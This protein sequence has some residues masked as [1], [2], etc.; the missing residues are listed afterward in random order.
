MSLNLPDWLTPTPHPILPTFTPEE[1]EEVIQRPGGAE[2]YADWFNKRETLIKLAEADPLRHGFE[3]EHTYPDGTVVKPW[4]DARKLLDEAEILGIF[5]GNRAAKSVFAAKSVC[6]AAMDFPGALIVCLSESEMTSIATQQKLIWLFL[7]KYIEPFNNKRDSTVKVNY[8]QAN[9]FSDK[10]LVFPNKSEMYFLTYNQDPGMFEGWEFGAQE[11]VLQR[12]GGQLRDAGKRVP[13]NVGAWADESLTLAWLQM[14]SRRLKFRKS[15]LIWA[16]TPVKGITPAIKEFVGSSAVTLKA[17]PSELLNKRKNFPELEPGTMP[18]IQRPVFPKSRAIYF[19]SIL[20]PFGGYYAS[21]KELCAPPKTE[22]YIERVAY[23]YARDSIARAFPKFSGVNIVKQCNLPADGTNY[24]LTDPAGTR[25]F[26]T[27][28]VR[29][30]PGNPANYYIYRDWPDL[31]RYGEWAVPTERE[32]DQENKKG[33]DG[34]KGPAQNALGYGVAQYKQL[35]LT[36]E[37]ITVPQA[38]SDIVNTTE[39][40]ELRVKNTAELIE[41]S[42]IDPYHKRIVSDAIAAGEDVSNLKE[43]IRT[44]FID[45]RAGKNEHI[46]EQGGTCLVDEFLKETKGVKTLPGMKFQLASGVSI[47]EGITE[48]NGLLH[49][50]SEQPLM[51]PNLPRLYVCEDCAQVRW[52]MENYTGLGGE[53]GACKDF[54]DLVRY[55][56]MS[57]LRYIAPGMLKTSGG[58]SY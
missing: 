17:L 20:N 19:H 5:G 29:V 40:I 3:P 1:L 45:P 8:S 21:I 11:S 13:V 30:A 47:A 52:A 49:W 44:R 27:I 23:G 25:N 39:D 12:V 42:F 43:I 14:F 55:M 24:M 38:I 48:V 4:D 51:Y 26:A 37:A 57:R 16:F 9:G 6:E 15:K 34:D 10:K 31:E 53:T 35:F 7:R 58:G 33:W 46:A 18:Y 22:E 32:V 54:I 56:A 50:E 36:E 41:K 28:W 2:W